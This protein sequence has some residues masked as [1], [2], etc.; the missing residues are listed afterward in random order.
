TRRIQRATYLLSIED[1]VTKRNKNG[2]V[3]GC[4]THP[5]MESFHH[6][7]KLLHPTSATIPGIS[8][9]TSGAPT[10]KVTPFAGIHARP[11]RGSTGDRGVIDQ[12]RTVL[13]GARSW[14]RL[15]GIGIFV[16]HKGI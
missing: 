7:R 2:K 8:P 15:L 13:V 1:G 6:P 3:L 16:R 11:V 12:Q 10:E 4:G 9:N 14:A 5:N